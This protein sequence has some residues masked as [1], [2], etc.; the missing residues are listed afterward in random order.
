MSTRRRVPGVRAPWAVGLVLF[1]M[2]AAAGGIYLS[3]PRD[4]LPVPQSV[5]DSRR[6]STVAAGQAIA[7]SLNGGLSSLAEIAAVVDES[8]RQRNRALLVPFKSRIWKSLY[9]VDRASHVVVAQVG[10]PA[11]PAVLGEPTPSEAGLRL[12][13]VGSAHQIVQY[14]PVGKPAEAKYLLVGHLDPSRLNDLLAVAGPEGAWLLDKSGSVIVGPNNRTPP[15]GVVDQGKEPGEDSSGSR[16]QRAAE[17]SEV[18][19]WATLSGRPPSNTLGWTV[20]SDQPTTDTVAPS[21]A[22]RQRAIT[23]SAV[24]AVLTVIVFAVLY[25]VLLRPIRLLRRVAE[26]ADRDVPR[27]PKHGEAGRVAAAFAPVQATQSTRKLTEGQ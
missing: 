25:L 1:L 7:R 24:L 3:R 27:A 2:L 16:A 8:M 23:V 26:S 12:A 18:I 14:T 11:Q 10:E 4:F 13:Q 5:L 20:V 15:Q 9:V 6:E 22:S 19:A 17:R 21:D